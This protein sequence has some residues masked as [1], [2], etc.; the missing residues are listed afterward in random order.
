MFTVYYRY[1]TPD[2]DFDE[3]YSTFA[4]LAAAEAEVEYLLGLED[5][6]TAYLC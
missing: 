4:T 5:V 2:G 1:A 3:D 6:L